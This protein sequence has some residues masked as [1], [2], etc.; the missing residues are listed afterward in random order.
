VVGLTGGTATFDTKNVGAGKTVSLNGASLTGADSQNY[1][2]TSVDNAK[3]DITK[4]TADSHSGQPGDDA[5]RHGAA[6]HIQGH[7][8][9]QQ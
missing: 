8:L 3:A 9:R 2:L 5:E 7:R 4:G 1:S 6:A